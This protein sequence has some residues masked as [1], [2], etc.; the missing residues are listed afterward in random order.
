MPGEEQRKDYVEDLKKQLP[1]LKTQKHWFAFVP[2]ARTP[3]LLL[4]KPA[5]IP[6]ADALEAAEAHALPSTEVWV[7]RVAFEDRALVFTLNDSLSK[8]VP[9]VAR[10]ATQLKRLAKETGFP[11]LAK[12]RVLDAAHLT[13]TAKPMAEDTRKEKRGRYKD[14]DAA[15]RT[16]RSQEADDQKRLAAM[17]GIRKDAASWLADH[18]LGSKKGKASDKAVD[19][20]FDALRAALAVTGEPPGPKELAVA[21]QLLQRRFTEARKA[22]QEADSPDA[23]GA[24]WDRLE[25]I[26]DD[27]ELLLETAD[28]RSAEARS[29]LRQIARQLESLELGERPGAAAP[30]T[31]AGFTGADRGGGLAVPPEAGE[32]PIRPEPGVKMV[33]R[34]DPVIFAD[35]ARKDKKSTDGFVA[36]VHPKIKKGTHCTVRTTSDPNTREVTAY[37]RVSELDYTLLG[38]GYVEARA[39]EHHTQKRG[40]RDLGT[41]APLFDGLPKPADVQQGVL[42]DC[43]LLAALASIASTKPRKLVQ[44]MVDNGDG[45][46]TVR[47]FQRIREEDK[48]DRYEPRYVRVRKSVQTKALG[49]AERARGALWV[50]MF[51]KAWAVRSDV[52]DDGVRAW[53]SYAGIEGGQ[54]AQALETILGE[55]THSEPVD[56]QASVPVGS[57]DKALDPEMLEVLTEAEAVAFAAALGERRPAGDMLLDERTLDAGLQKLGLKGQLSPTA[58]QVF[59]TRADELGKKAVKMPGDPKWANGAAAARML[60]ER[61]ERG[62]VEPDLD[63]VRVAYVNGLRRLNKIPG[64]PGSGRYTPTQLEVWEKIRLAVEAGRQ[65]GAG[66]P[67]FTGPKQPFGGE[68][69]QSGIAGTHAYTVLGVRRHERTDGDPLLFVEVRNPWG[70]YGRGY[71]QGKDGGLKPTWKLGGTSHVE[72]TDFLRTFQTVAYS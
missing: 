58:G 62:E 50:Q 41:E 52:L 48:P 32:L 46:V 10:M 60:A 70:F 40:H 3:L 71:K 19:E 24:A 36:G 45:T 14:V 43:Y 9:R 39:V 49:F 54:V 53:A 12:A 69:L 56:P 17:H 34:A 20:M 15:Q 42:G 13:E 57:V 25:A 16:L 30:R 44:A 26:R 55:P 35:V 18:V 33:F 72:L 5:R 37:V 2:H 59:K 29:T 6:L 38:S 64:P 22:W 51:E 1:L 66:T 7:G 65:V 61:I 68:A 23:K 4:N 21:A 11:L 8:G 27:V 28:D 47:L 63:A 31:E 67:E